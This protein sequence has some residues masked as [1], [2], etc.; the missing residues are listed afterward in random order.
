[1]QRKYWVLETC[2]NTLILVP[3]LIKFD[4]EES[5]ERAEGEGLT[6]SMI[7]T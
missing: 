2:L 5:K 4:L 6:E 1:M 3:S 7:R